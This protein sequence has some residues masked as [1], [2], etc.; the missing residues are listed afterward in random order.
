M[1]KVSFDFDS[2]SPMY[3]FDTYVAIAGGIVSLATLVVCLWLFPL[4][5]LPIFAMTSFCLLYY[6]LVAGIYHAWRR[7]LMNHPTTT[8]SVNDS[9]Q[10]V[11]S[12]FGREHMHALADCRVLLGSS[13][14][15]HRRQFAHRNGYLL[16]IPGKRLYWVGSNTT[17]VETL[18]DGGARVGGTWFAE[19]LRDVF[20]FTVAAF[21][22]GAALGVAAF[23]LEW[24]PITVHVAMGCFIA[25][26]AY[27][28]SYHQRVGVGWKLFE[29]SGVLVIAVITNFHLPYSAVY[30][31]SKLIAVLSALYLRRCLCVPTAP[32]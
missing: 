16:Q 5:A 22:G 11:I 10:V 26:F 23:C 28:L 8:I 15:D 29:L 21:I 4:F 24:E 7:D 6:L 3:C 31:S 32:S 19:F 9:K 12:E 20:L 30:L 2:I 18:V 27:A 13:L 1:R 14:L 17:F 25:S